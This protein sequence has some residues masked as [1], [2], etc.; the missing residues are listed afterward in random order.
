MTDNKYYNEDSNKSNIN[1]I[2]EGIKN[3]YKGKDEQDYYSIEELERADR[4]WERTHL[5]KN[6]DRTSFHR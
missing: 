5:S 1:L 4:E 2:P 3:P 6:E